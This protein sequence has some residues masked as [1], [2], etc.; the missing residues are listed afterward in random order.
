MSDRPHRYFFIHI[1]KTAGSA[2]RMRLI[3][4]F[5]EAAVY[6]SR[7]LDGIE[8]IE[9]YISPDHL[10]DRLTAR[11]DQ[12]QVITG[13]FPLRTV[14]VIGGQVTTLTL[15]REPVDRTLS[16]L[17][18]QR[19]DP[20][21]LRFLARQGGASQSAGGSLE[22]I[23]AA[24]RGLAQTDNTM[25]RML[26]LAPEEMVASMLMPVSIGRDHLERAK[27]A[28]AG[29]DV[30]GFQPRFEE[31]CEE[32]SS[33]FGWSLG[34]PQELNAT[35]PIEAAEGL[36]ATIA[37]DNSLDIELYEFAKELTA[38]ETLAVRP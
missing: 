13:H 14:D 20:S 33:R 9:L 38:R 4:H 12:I 17:R 32:L 5:G 35:A 2:L 15:L 8:G 22:E 3:H 29:V 16:H 21:A 26:S 25:T 1:M 28:L 6:P 37:E 36:R 30:V 23:Y 7:G 11:G 19:E 34:E 27:E 18:Q 24:G 10:R 31:F